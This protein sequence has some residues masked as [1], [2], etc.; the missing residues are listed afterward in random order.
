MLKHRKIAIVLTVF[1]IFQ[2]CTRC[3]SIKQEA[4]SAGEASRVHLEQESTV[5][6]SFTELNDNADEPVS[7][8]IGSE[9]K[10]SGEEGDQS[11]ESTKEEPEKHAIPAAA[12]LL[13]KNPKVQ[14]AV[15]EKGIEVAGKLVDKQLKIIDEA[16]EKAENFLKKEDQIDGPSFLGV[17]FDGRGKYS[18]ESRKMSICKDI[19]RTKQGSIS[20]SDFDLRCPEAEEGSGDD[21]EAVIDANNNKQNDLFSIKDVPKWEELNK[22]KSRF[23]V[24]ID[25]QKDLKEPQHGRVII[26]KNMERRIRFFE[27]RWFT[28]SKRKVFHLYNGFGNGGSGNPKNKKISVL[29]LVLSFEEDR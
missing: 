22:A 17:G 24:K 8:R 9:D 12:M 11:E 25:M 27:N 19:V 2:G 4:D 15:I 21:E 10:P 16:Q 1:V 14:E 5:D 28:E 13:M 18:P 20:I 7:K 29:G 23:K 6:F 3:E 26:S